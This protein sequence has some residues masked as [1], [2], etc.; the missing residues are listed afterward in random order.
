Y[1]ASLVA[2][3]RRRGV[4]VR[5]AEA[6]RELVVEDGGVTVTTTRGRLRARVLVG[7]DGAG[8]LVRKRLRPRDPAPIRLFRG[9]IEAP[10][11]WRDR[12]DMVYDFSLMRDRACP[13]PSPVRGGRLNAGLMHSPSTRISG[14]ALSEPLDRG[15]RRHGV[16]VDPGA[17][18]G[19]PAWGYA[20]AAPVAAPHLLTLG[21][22]AGIDAL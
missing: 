1:D 5:E 12:R 14:A 9:E 10:P 20:P 22:A 17:V 21:D 6:L 7:A 15:L 13:C 2:Q 19:W 8:S 3:I 16:I 18:R 4:E 11:A